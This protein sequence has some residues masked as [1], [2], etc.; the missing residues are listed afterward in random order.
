MS[1]IEIC[2]IASSA[3]SMHCR[4][5]EEMMRDDA[6]AHALHVYSRDSTS[7]WKDVRKMANTKIPLANW[8]PNLEML[9]AL[10]ILL[11]C[12][13][14]TFQSYSIVFMILARRI[15]FVNMLML[16]CRILE[17]Q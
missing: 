5:N 7:F 9:L 1:L 15:L 12:S 11:S 6:L 4:A 17:F 16:Y 8:Q 14:L 13:R 2:E 10:L 3:L